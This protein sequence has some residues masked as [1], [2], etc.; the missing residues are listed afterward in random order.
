MP[1]S[2]DNWDNPPTN[3]IFASSTQAEGDIL[4][5]SV[6][7]N[8]QTIF[9]TPTDVVAGSYEF[10]FTSGATGDEWNNKWTNASFTL[11][12]I[13]S[14][15]F[16]GVDNNTVTLSDNKFYVMNWEN[17][18]YADTRAIFME[19]DAAPVSIT[20]VSQ[21]IPVPSPAQDVE[22]TVTTDNNPTENVYVRYTTDEWVSSSV[23]ACSFTGN[24]G[25]ATI[26]A[27]ITE[28]NVEYY[29]L[30][31]SILSPTSDYDLITINFDNNSNSNYNYIVEEE[32]ILSCEGA[33]GVLTTDPVFPMHN[34]NVIITFDATGG[35]GQLMNYAGDIYAHT[36]LITSESEGNND[37]QYIVSEWGVNDADFLFTEIDDNL[38]QLT[39]T[40]IRAF[41]GVPA[42]EEIYKI[43]MVIRADEPTDPENPNNFLVARN[44][45]GT[46]FNLD[47]YTAGINVKIASN[48][49]K[50]PLVPINEQVAIC[51]YALDATSINLKIDETP[52]ATIDDLHLMY[53]LNTADYTSGMHEIIAIADDGTN[54][55]YDTTWFYIRGDVVIED[56]PTGMKNG[57][58]YIDETTV[59]LVLFDP[60]IDK[61]FAF[62]IGDF[63][64]WTAS[65]NGYMKRT[66]DGTHYWTTITGLTAGTEYA[67]Q[68]YIDG[69]LKLADPYCDKIL[70]PW[71]DR[72]IPE[73]IYPDLKV[74][75]WDLTLGTVSV[76]ETGQDDYN[77]IINDFIPSAVN[78]TQ[79]NL[80][81]YELLIRDFVESKDIKDIIDTLDYLQNLGIN[82]IELMPISEFDGNDSW[83]YAPNF[84]YAPDKAYGTKDD[85]KRFIDECHQ[86]GIAVI[87]DVVYNHMYGGSPFVQM[88]WNSE[89]NEPADNSAWFNSQATHPYSIGYDF[90]HESGHTKELV[91]DNLT[92]WMTEYKIDGFR[93]DLSKGFTQNNSGGDVGA[94]SAYDQSRVDIILDYYNHTK[95]V[96]PNA[97]FIL[98]HLAD[99]SEEVVLA[100]AG[101]MLWGV[102]T[103]QIAQTTMGW[104]TNHDFSWANYQDRGYTYP[105]LIP[106]MESHDEERIMFETVTYGNGFSGDTTASLQRMEAIAAM[107]MTIPGPKMLWQFEELGYDESIFLC[108]DGS[109]SD[110][111]R[112]SSKPIHWNYM[113]DQKRQKLYWTY[114]GM[115]KLKT[116]NPAFINGSFGQD[117]SGLGKKMWITDGS[118]NVSV[119]ANFATNSFDMAPNFQHTGTWYNYFT[120]ESIDV[121]DANGH[122]LYYTPGDYY[123][124]TDV[125]LDRPYANL[126]F[127]VKNT[128]DANIENANIII[129]GYGSSN[130]DVSGNTDFIYGTNATVN[131]I[132]SATGYTSET[133]TVTIGNADQIEYVVLE[134]VV[135]INET[136]ISDIQL[137]PNPTNDYITVTSNQLY[138]ISIFDIT[139]K[140]IETVK[141]TTN[142]QT[143]DLSNLTSGIYTFT[144]KNN[145]KIEVKKVIVK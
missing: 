137:Y 122:T 46:D 117:Q 9:S 5:N 63:N 17:T 68:Y 120:G 95:S 53:G 86:R 101:C 54:F 89:T 34:G 119:T 16:N 94:W 23:V 92:Y 35:N 50:D 61:D 2:W 24:T 91:K 107:Y 38:Y 44:A 135:N 123:V 69:E 110:D 8:Y 43:T 97:Y 82:A 12:S 133:G 40:D 45:D 49:N 143:I 90:N 87:M 128:S 81:I 22:I 13:A 139:G 145:S 77:W 130:T 113:N 138:E 76:F 106:Y 115:A 134:S 4:L 55:A 102:M 121:S 25:T 129:T 75:P 124:F 65:D 125:Q 74:Y 28:T 52:V 88:Y 126:Q 141:M 67:Y 136:E 60:S 27:Q 36:G 48:L 39:I 70:D 15:T 64:N 131:Y 109:F 116:E 62:A 31:T 98:E 57:I 112:T 37:W 33:S 118:M 59:T 127:N 78:G 58:N 85:Y 100:N 19:L 56:L 18:N 140:Q 84:Y 105:N 83:G 79:S 111:C 42:D 103:T 30:T 72:W 99:N 73:T 20:D 104:D 21:D 71:N 142:N 132:A 80:I 6:T 11:N 32:F 51:V 96:N 144:F 7:N 108:Y 93:F 14:L 114:A 29:I 10:L 66:T 47:V 1:G 41:Y 26:P 3:S